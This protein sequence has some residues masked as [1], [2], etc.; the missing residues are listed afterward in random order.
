MALDLTFLLNAKD[1]ASTVFDK[2][3]KSGES[4]ADGISGAFGGALNKFNL[5]TGAVGTMAT[6]AAGGAFTA[7]IK[8]TVAWTGEAVA[9]SKSLGITT[10]AASILNVALGD[11]Y[12]SKDTMLAGSA[13]I[14]K[15]LKSE[16]EAFH[17]LGVATRDQSGHYRS[18]LSIMTDV[19][20]KLGTLKEG[21]DRNVAGMS[22]YGKSWTELS[23]LI[24]LN[25][26]VMDEAGKKAKELGLLVG[27]EQVEQSKKYK[28][29]LND[30][31]DVGKSLTVR[32]G[33]VL[34]PALV[35]VGAFLGN[36]G[37]VLA[38][39]FRWSLN[40]VGFAVTTVGELI[41]LMAFRA[42]SAFNIIKSGLT[43]DF[44]GAKRQF[45][46]MVAAGDDYNKRTRSKWN[47]DWSKDKEITSKQIKGDRVTPEDPDKEAKLKAAATKLAA[48][49][50]KK[51]D[52]YRAQAK[53]ILEIEQERIKTLLEMEKE[54]L[55]KLK[56]NYDTA[57]SHLDSFRTSYS[58]VLDSIAGRDKRLAEEQAAALRGQEDSYS[59]YYRLRAELRDAE[60][61]ADNDPAWSNDSIAKKL[62]LYDDMITRAEQYR[63][64]ARAGKV[65]NVSAEQAE[66]DFLATKINLETKIKSLGDGQLKQ[67]ENL[68]VKAAEAVTVM[69]K[70]I[71]VQQDQL[72][73]VDQMLKNIPNIT[74]KEL[75]IKISGLG[76]LSRIQALTGGVEAS[77]GA[78]YFGD[79]YTM[80]GKTYWADG[81]LAEDG[82]TVAGARAS[83]GPVSPY[84]S[85]LVGEKGPEIIRMG[86]QGGTVI[87]NDRLTAGAVTVTIGDIIVQGGAT[88]TETA[89]DIARKIYPELQRL[90]GNR[91]VA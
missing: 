7:I 38:N 74:E 30:I 61:A 26:G 57:V 88:A 42:Y 59:Q 10:E 81:T 75:R 53:S 80:G 78:Q 44:S 25:N 50:K 35:K 32:F 34:L 6:I 4:A 72:K 46:D 31:E 37:P 54:Y 47:E 66:A 23:G 14:A 49:L 16:E 20:T 22:I 89:R 39:V 5:L 13:R 8:E 45:Q 18:T 48:E 58:S 64:D 56:G 77:T 90:A 3:K 69:E 91:L 76:D 82:T 19:N 17:K 15:T 71:K 12:L 52:L 55:T 68:A 27:E 51:V 11:V 43:G 63:N 21:T 65:E 84:H 41:G 67:Q 24:K 73:I 33:N 9:L 79:Y 62:K 1:N 83:G 70:A 86:S 87:P 85:Y 28:A 60:A 29:A 36:N 40:A 2:V